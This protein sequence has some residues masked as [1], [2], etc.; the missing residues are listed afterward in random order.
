MTFLYICLSY[1]KY[2]K[3]IIYYLF[4]SRLKEL[5][6]MFLSKMLQEE[7]NNYGCIPIARPAFSTLPSKHQG[8][9][10]RHDLTVSQIL[11]VT[12]KLRQSLPK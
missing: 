7:N 4:K 1:I 10:F 6:K 11:R 3:V 12:F 5:I 2:H 8:K 9:Y